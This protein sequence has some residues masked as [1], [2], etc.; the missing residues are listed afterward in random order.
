MEGIRRSLRRTYLWLILERGS[1]AGTSIPASST[2][3]RHD[4]EDNNWVWETLFEL[5]DPTRFTMMA[6]PQMLASLLSRMLFLGDSWS[7]RIG[8]TYFRYRGTTVKRTISRT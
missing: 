6:S 7:F 2:E 5:M 1:P 4:H 8:A 3:R